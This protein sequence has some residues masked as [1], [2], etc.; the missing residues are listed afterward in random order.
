MTPGYP[1]TEFLKAPGSNVMNPSLYTLPDC[2]GLSSTAT[3]F[4][5]NLQEKDALD[6]CAKIGACHLAVCDQVLFCTLF[7]APAAVE[8]AEFTFTSKSSFIKYGKPVI[9]SGETVTFNVQVSP[10]TLDIPKT[11]SRK[12]TSSSTAATFTSW[13]IIAGISGSVLILM[14]VAAFL[15]KRAMSKRNLFGP[16]FYPP[17]LRTLR[18]RAMMGDRR[19]TQALMAARMVHGNNLSLHNPASSV[20]MGSASTHYLASQA[21]PRMIP[22]ASQ[23]Q[24]AAYNQSPRPLSEPQPPYVANMNLGLRSDN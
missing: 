9:I 14:I 10:Q 17:D 22:Q 2:K 8:R 4:A 5:R 12:S 20:R 18:L 21:P 13:P 1:Y 11:P 7:M 24:Y 3:C 23:A 6:L 15:L 16:R 19:A